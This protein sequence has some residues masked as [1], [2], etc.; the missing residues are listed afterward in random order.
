MICNLCTKKA[1]LSL[2]KVALTFANSLKII[3]AYT[4]RMMILAS[5]ESTADAAVCSAGDCSL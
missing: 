1:F 2:F 4:P 3:R 5:P